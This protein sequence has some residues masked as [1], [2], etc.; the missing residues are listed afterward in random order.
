MY[1]RLCFVLTLIAA[2][3]GPELEDEAEQP[4]EAFAIPT[5]PVA[6]PAPP[7]GEALFPEWHRKTTLGAEHYDF[8]QCE[9]VDVDLITKRTRLTFD[10]LGPLGGHLNRTIGNN[11]CATADCFL[12]VS[13]SRAGGTVTIGATAIVDCDDPATQTAGSCDVSVASIAGGPSLYRGNVIVADT[14]RIDT[15]L[16]L[17]GL[18]L[19]LMAKN[20]IEF[21]ANGRIIGHAAGQPAAAA[22]NAVDN[23]LPY[24]QCTTTCTNTTNNP[25]EPE[26]S[27]TTRCATY[28]QYYEG[29]AGAA[30]Q[31]SGSVVLIAPNIRLPASTTH[32]QHVQLNG[33]RGGNGGGLGAIPCPAS[34]NTCANHAIAN[35]RSPGR[36][37]AG[38]NAGKLI[39]IADRFYGEALRYSTSSG[40]SGSHGAR[41]LLRIYNNNTIQSTQAVGAT[42]PNNPAAAAGWRDDLPVQPRYYDYAFLFG[43]RAADRLAS[44]AYHYAR[45]VHPTSEPGRTNKAI[46]RGQLDALLENFCRTLQPVIIFPQ[47]ARSTV[48]AAG[49]P[50]SYLTSAVS[51]RRAEVCRQA[52]ARRDRLIG[53][54]NWF[55]LPAEFLMY[56]R[57][58]VVANYRAQLLAQTDSA[59][60]SFNNAANL[61]AAQLA[62]LEVREGQAL[63][64]TRK[65]AEIAAERLRHLG[66][67]VTVSLARL[68]R[69]QKALDD[70]ELFLSYSLDVIEGSLERTECDFFCALGQFFQIVS[71]IASFASNALSAINGV[72]GFI[73]GL[74]NIFDTDFL[75]SQLES[76]LPVRFP[77]EGINSLK[78]LGVYADAVFNGAS[79]GGESVPGLIGIGK[80]VKETI[81]AWK[82]ADAAISGFNATPADHWNRITYATE[83]THLEILRALQD[84]AEAEARVEAIPNGAVTDKQQ[85]LGHLRYVQTLLQHRLDL[86]Q[87][88]AD[89][90]EEHLLAL[91]ELKL[92]QMEHDLASLEVTN[93]ENEITRLKCRLGLLTGAQCNG[94]AAETQTTRA[95]RDRLCESGRELADATLL[96]DFYYQRSKDFVLLDNTFRPADESHNFQ[97]KLLRDVDRTAFDAPSASP[98]IDDFLTQL[99]GTPPFGT[100]SGAFCSP[101]RDCGFGVTPEE[102]TYQGTVMNSLI[103]TGR[104]KLDLAAECDLGQSWSYCNPSLFALEQPRQRVVSFDVEL[105]MAPG[106]RLGCT[107]ASCPAPVSGAADQPNDPGLRFRVR[108][109]HGDV[110]S[111]LWDDLSVRDFYFPEIYPRQACELAKALSGSSV[112]CRRASDFG[113]LADYSAP[114]ANVLSDP[115]ALT[116]SAYS[117]SDLFGTSVRG[118]WE[119]DLG[120][121]LAQL[122]SLDACY[123]FASPAASLPQSCWPEECLSPCFTDHGVRRSDPA[124]PAYCACYDASNQRLP[125]ADC[126]NLPATLVW[127]RDQGTVPE[128]CLPATN[129]PTRMEALCKRFVT[130]S[131]AFYPSGSPTCCTADGRLR[132]DLSAATITSCAASG[133]DSDASCVAPTECREI[134]GPRCK[135]FK[136]SL[137]GFEYRIDWR[138]EN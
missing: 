12:R 126:A 134:C 52:E 3:A 72:V 46:A 76:D 32:A 17:G 68:K 75:V 90:I 38:G 105:K 10:Q 19:V 16:N 127:A 107:S 65:A 93:L 14:I 67:V 73:K 51:D 31:N 98:L 80:D 81:D 69:N 49:A 13:S 123:N 77:R 4:S 122:N 35:A 119:L 20:T 113:G 53:D 48:R 106:Y 47:P 94:I 120:E 42:P 130:S 102:R 60:T 83:R 8:E 97:R 108:Y 63:A 101:G 137:I 87:Q 138:A 9:T 92:A 21:T 121:T 103:R 25:Y 71:A 117:S 45:Y 110:A 70:T 112:D 132:G 7:T 23:I 125:S 84:I 85:A 58:D 43:R 34:N 91:G 124:A 50:A 1:R 29:Y 64:E 78:I 6:V 104:A 33:Q 30:G 115:P 96:F 88:N 36:G 99:L 109:K 57:P 59:R 2:C 133:F 86:V 5:F 55:G 89:L 82:Q 61:S 15:T 26:P 66:E 40:A 11:T 39:T 100:V 54:L 128:A 41:A 135:A 56:L 28:P 129:E 131:G 118:E 114:S 24:P 111:F 18:S 95:R 136:R 62:A 116:T 74:D 79:A 22:R 27:C 44:N 37:G